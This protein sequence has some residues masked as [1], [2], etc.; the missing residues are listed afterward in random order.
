MGSE[1][2]FSP[3]IENSAPPVETTR[4]RARPPPAKSGKA[5]KVML[6]EQTVHRMVDLILS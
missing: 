5:S 1:Q 2:S 3:K 4:A 6:D